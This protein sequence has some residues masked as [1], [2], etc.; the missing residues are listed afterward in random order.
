MQR[1]GRICLLGWTAVLILSFHV[2]CG[3]AMPSIQDF[4]IQPLHAPL[5]PPPDLSSAVRRAL[6]ER[7]GAVLIARPS[8]GEILLEYRTPRC[9]GRKF[10]AGSLLKLV[11]AYAGLEE[12]AITEGTRFLC[13]AAS[14]LHPKEV[15]GQGGNSSAQVPPCSDPDGHGFIAVK[16]ALSHSCNVFF[17]QLGR[18]L[19]R[20][21]LSHYA[22]ILG[23]GKKTF[24]KEAGFL[25]YGEDSPLLDLLEVGN[26]FQAIARKGRGFLLHNRRERRQ[27]FW[28]RPGKDSFRVIRRALKEAVR[29]GTAQR[30]APGGFSATSS[31]DPGLFSSL[32]SP[33]QILG[34]TGTAT[35]RASPRGNHGWFGG[36]APAENPE[37]L[38]VVFVFNGRGG[39]TAAPVAREILEVYFREDR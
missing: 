24:G 4:P 28:I 19:G 3:P 7:E 9:R 14:S 6:H 13:P 25:G 10:P 33:P 30:A 23:F 1:K 38:I 39:T 21:K 36:F 31:E 27:A 26:L 37:I 17:F 34:K 35:F 18:K 22:A 12:G 11:T 16:E 8:S 29:S 15:S 5:P 20:R 2:F 32:S